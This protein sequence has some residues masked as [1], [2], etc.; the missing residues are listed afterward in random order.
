MWH[1]LSTAF[2]VYV[3]HPERGAGYAW[4]S[5]AGSCL[6]YLAILGAAYKRVNCEE[7]GCWRLGHR[8]PGHGRPV[9]RRHYHSHKAPLDLPQNPF[10]NQRSTT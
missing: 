6:T 8:H 3:L 5:G 4:W 2:S 9:C 1:W 10:D 7:H